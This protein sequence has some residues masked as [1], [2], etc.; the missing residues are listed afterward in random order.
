M[1]EFSIVSENTFLLYDLKNSLPNDWKGI[2][3]N[4]LFGGNTRP[5][6]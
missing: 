5:N 1:C 6:Q 3:I 4:N 2:L